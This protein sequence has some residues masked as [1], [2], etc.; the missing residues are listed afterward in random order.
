MKC[1]GTHE[2]KLIL[3]RFVNEMARQHMTQPREAVAAVLKELLHNPHVAAER[4][5]QAV[6]SR[7]S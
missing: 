5:A 4:G 2:E 7:A 6:S 1:H 3:A